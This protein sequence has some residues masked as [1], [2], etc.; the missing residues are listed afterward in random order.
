MTIS[1]NTRQGGGHGKKI[2]AMLVPAGGRLLLFNT[3]VPATLPHT[4]GSKESSTAGYSGKKGK[5]FEITE[6]TYP[7]GLLYHLA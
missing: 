3:Q 7:H 4:R 2:R 5:C 1:N 6:L